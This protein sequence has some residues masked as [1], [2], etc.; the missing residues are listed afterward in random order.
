[1][2]NAD[3]IDALASIVA[4]RIPT[5]FCEARDTILESINAAME[6]AQEQEKEATLSL[7]ISVKWPLNSTAVIVSMPVNVR[8]RYEQSANLDD[9][10]QPQLPMGGDDE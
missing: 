3:R 5:L 2:N 6:E 7:S 4:S 10:N 1:M 9:P 8:R